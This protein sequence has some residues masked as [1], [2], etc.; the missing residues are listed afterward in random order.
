MLV[1]GYDP[2][3]SV[4]AATIGNS[5][6]ACT[7][8]LVGRYGGDWLLAR[9]FRISPQQQ[10]RAEAWYQRYGSYSLLVSWLPVLG[11]PLCLV[12]GLL[13]IHFLKFS[14]LVVSGKLVRYVA[15]AWVTLRMAN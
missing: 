3:S 1:K 4:L 9:L 14:L 11:D 6:G 7:T 13:K 15:V 8:W 10:Q 2:A 12:G 5:L